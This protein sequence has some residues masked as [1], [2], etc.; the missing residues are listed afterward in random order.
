MIETSYFAVGAKLPHAVS[1]ARMTP[2][3]CPPELKSYL[4]LA[5]SFKML[6]LPKHE[7]VIQFRRQLASLDPL[8]VAADLEGKC[9]LCYEKQGDWCHRHMVAKWLLGAGV[10]VKERTFGGPVD[11]GGPVPFIIQQSVEAPP[12]PPPPPQL[13]FGF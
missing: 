1:I 4:A 7:Y 13:E 3:W 11:V 9:L 8:K 12:P 2:K 6:H 10:I 5:P